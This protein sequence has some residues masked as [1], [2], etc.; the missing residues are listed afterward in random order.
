VSGTPQI[1]TVPVEPGDE[2]KAGT[3]ERYLT[4]QFSETVP[5]FSPDGRWMAYESNELEDQ[6]TRLALANRLI[7]QAVQQNPNEKYVISFGGVKPGKYDFHCTPHLAMNM[8]GS[9]TVQ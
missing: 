8:K 6:S 4:S 7:L 2:P 3:P 1:W 9:V 5:M